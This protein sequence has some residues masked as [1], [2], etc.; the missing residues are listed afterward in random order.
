MNFPKIFILILNSSYNPGQNI[1]N[2]V[3]KSTEARR[4]KRSLSVS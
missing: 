3:E 2:S 4:G 1:W